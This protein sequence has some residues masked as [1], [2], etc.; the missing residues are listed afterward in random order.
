MAVALTDLRADLAAETA[1]LRGV[2]AAVPSDDL[3]RPTPAAGWSIADQ[4]THLA[5]F[6]DAARRAIEDPDA[7]R[8][9]A[10]DAMAMGP[11]FPDRIAAQFRSL[12]GQAVLD[13]FD[14]S[15]AKLLAAV[16]TCDGGM[17]IPWYGVEMS[18]ASSTTARIMETWAHGQ[19]IVDA[20]GVTLA[21]THRLRHIAHIGISARPFTY[22][23][24]GKAVPE[25][26]LRIEL[27]APDG[28]VWTWGPE[29]ATD[30]VRG[31]AFEFCR[32]VTQRTDVA[33][34]ALH[35][36]GAAAQEW[37]EIAQAYAGAPGPG[38]PARTTT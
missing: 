5:Y 28:S 33:D 10:A 17:R 26:P 38:R 6:D 21:P 4:L 12:T 16:E 8:A 7:F 18:V 37:I 31:D 2:L 34:T 19:D 15:R 20:L 23:I 3:H 36:A 9:D 32:V 24:R 14:S 11:D 22:K 35:V 27:D 29:G 1:D 13:W 30:V 25:A